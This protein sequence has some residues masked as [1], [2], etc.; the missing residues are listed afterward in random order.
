MVIGDPDKFPQTMF[1][2]DRSISIGDVTDGTS[3]TI[4]IVEV[5]R[6][7]PWTMPGADLHFDR[8]TFRINGG[9]ASISSAHA[10]IAQVALADGSVYPLDDW[11]RAETLRNLMQPADGNPVDAF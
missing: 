9:P 5:E 1:T 6:G 4:M 7:V 3:N 8:M 11:L 10:G 2:P